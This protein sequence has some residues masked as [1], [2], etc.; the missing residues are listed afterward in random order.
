MLQESIGVLRQ[1]ALIGKINSDSI[2][3]LDIK[4]WAL[5]NWIGVKDVFYIDQQSHFFVAIF[6]S[7]ESRDCVHRFKGWFFLGYG[8]YTLI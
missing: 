5:K 6:E 7:K 2:D 8:L 1:S 3:I 4:Q